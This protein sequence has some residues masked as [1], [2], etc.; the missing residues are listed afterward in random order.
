M[1]QGTQAPALQAH[2]AQDVVKQAA[3]ITHHRQSL[4]LVFG[5]GRGHHHQPVGLRHANARWG[6]RPITRTLIRLGRAL[7]P[8]HLAAGAA[9]DTGLAFTHRHFQG[10]P[11]QI[12][13]PI[14]LGLL[15]GAI[16]PLG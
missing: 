6:H 8:D 4:G 11:A 1:A 9:Q 15:G 3:R 7:A 12:G 16:G 2:S 14:A 5:C 10:A 13:H